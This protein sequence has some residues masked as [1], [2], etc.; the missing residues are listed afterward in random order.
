MAPQGTHRRPAPA[1]SRRTPKRTIRKGRLILF[2]ACIAIIIIAIVT[3]A[4]GS[5][6]AKWKASVEDYNVINP[7]DLGVT[8]QVTNTGTRPGTPTCTVNAQDPSGAY[9]GID[10]GTLNNAVRPGQTATYVDNVT[11][12]HQGAQY[13]TQVTVSC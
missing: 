7:A 6:G 9:S 12:T 8:V 13:V 4:S 2:L 1:T 5:S 3:L 11:I 10:I